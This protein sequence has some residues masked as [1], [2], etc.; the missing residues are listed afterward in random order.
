M[1][2]D[3]YNIIE[4]FKYPLILYLL[5]PLFPQKSQDAQLLCDTGSSRVYINS[6]VFYLTLNRLSPSLKSYSPKETE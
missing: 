2:F 6:T 1:S 5:S 4:R 3:S